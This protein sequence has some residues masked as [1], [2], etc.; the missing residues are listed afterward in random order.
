MSYWSQYSAYNT[1]I[2]SVYSKVKSDKFVLVDG[3]AAGE[4]S[5]PF[6]LAK[7]VIL[8]VRF[9]PRG[10]GEVLKSG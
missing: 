8:A 10:E 9:E 2:I 7:S 4:L 3:G 1:G 6:D 5:E